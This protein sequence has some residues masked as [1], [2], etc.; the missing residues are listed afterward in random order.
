[1]DKETIKTIIADFHDRGI[2]DFIERDIKMVPVY[3]WLLKN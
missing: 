1:M 3:E 2:H